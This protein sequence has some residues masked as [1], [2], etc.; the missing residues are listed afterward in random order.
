MSN[1]ITFGVVFIAALAGGAV[2]WQMHNQGEVSRASTAV[3]VTA[4]QPAAMPVVGFLNSGSPD[5]YAPMVA[6]FRQGL[7]ETGYVEGQNVAIEYRWAEGA[8]D[9]LPALA[10]DLVRRGV[11]VIC[12][13]TPPAVL[14]AKAEGASL[15]TIAATAG[16]SAAR[17]ETSTWLRPLCLAR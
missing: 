12:A 5:S 1:R 6:A 8:Y 7:K 14:A 15:R 3:A 17:S 16:C 4:P 11:A 9:R 2:L 13:G 10:A